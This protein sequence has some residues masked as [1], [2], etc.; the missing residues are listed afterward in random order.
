MSPIIELVPLVCCRC[1]TP[2][3]AQADEAAWVC[4]NCGQGLLLSDSAGTAPLAIHYAAGIPAGKPGRPFWV[5]DGQV[6][7]QRLIYGGGDQSPNAQAFW[8]TPRR[9]YVP[10]YLLELQTM[11]DVGTNLLLQ[12]PVLNA[13]TPAPFLPV[14]LAPADIQPMAEF[15]VMGIEAARKDNLKEVQ[16]SLKLS[17]PELWIVP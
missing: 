9:F 17:A 8:Q 12:A 3:P 16:F 13:G 7:L 5:V 2:V 1:Q 14:T 4:A 10:A 11:V 6:A 15:I